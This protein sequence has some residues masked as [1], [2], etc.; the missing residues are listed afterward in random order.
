M[1]AWCAFG[2]SEGYRVMTEDEYEVEKLIQPVKP[3]VEDPSDQDC[4]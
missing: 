2:S 3:V 1:E 4:A